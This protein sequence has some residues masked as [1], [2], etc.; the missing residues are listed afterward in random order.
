MG[1]RL[2]GNFKKC[3]FDKKC[4]EVTIRNYMTMYGKDCDSDG[5]ITC[6]DYGLMYPIGPYCDVDLAKRTHF[7]HSFYQTPCVNQCKLLTILSTKIEPHHL[8]WTKDKLFQPL[9]LKCMSQGMKCN[10]VLIPC[11]F[12]SHI[13]P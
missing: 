1:G 5:S 8:V 4:A 6:L 3:A 10:I 13:Q 2:S 7:W 12:S 11:F 9:K